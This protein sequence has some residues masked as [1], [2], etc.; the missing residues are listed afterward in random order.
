MVNALGGSSF[1]SISNHR[2]GKIFPVDGLI[3]FC[4]EIQVD[5]EDVIMLVIA[6][7]MDASKM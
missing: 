5:P 7:K 3:K 2:N 1:L 6:Y 4:A